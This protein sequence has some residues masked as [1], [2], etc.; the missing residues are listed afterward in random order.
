[1]IM[2]AWY[3][4]SGLL[5]EQAGGWCGPD[6]RVTRRLGLWPLAGSSC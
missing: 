5:R 4:G 1:M 3:W 2:A 6:G